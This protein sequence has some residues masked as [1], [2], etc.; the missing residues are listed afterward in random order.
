MIF[1]FLKSSFII[2]KKTLGKIKPSIIPGLCWFIISTILLTLPGSSFPTENWLDKI[3]FDKWVHIIM[4]AL[5]VFLF[6]WGIQR[7]YNSEKK[8]N[9]FILIAF[10]CAVYGIS[11]EYV[12]RNFIPNRSFDTGDI[13]A[14]VIGCFAGWWLAKK[15][16][17]STEKNRPL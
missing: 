8:N 11:M 17:G 14:D 7:R 15:L 2:A 12:Q 4:F 10:A 16:A 5:L 9:I 6:C 3:W 13:I 1:L